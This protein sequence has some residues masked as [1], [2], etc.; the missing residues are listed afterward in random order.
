MIRVLAIGHLSYD[1]TFPLDDFPEENTKIQIPEIYESAGGPAA[2]AAALLAC[3]KIPT[4]FAGLVGADSYGLRAVMDLKTHGVDTRLV[5]NRENYSTPLSF[6]LVNKMNGSR[7]IVNRKGEGA[8]HP[9]D[10]RKFFAPF[11]SNPPELLLFDGHE[12]EVSLAAI[13]C[14][15]EAVTVLD[16][17]SRRTGTELLAMRVDYCIASERFAR[18][19]IPGKSIEHTFSYRELLEALLTLGVR[20]P[21]VTL[22]E[23]GCCFLETQEKAEAFLLPAYPARAVDTTGAGDIFHGA[24]AAALLQGKSFREALRVATAASAL[25]VERYGGMTSI[26]T[27]EEV[28]QKI[29]GDNVWRSL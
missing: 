16:A 15:P 8:L 12:P 9:E 11:L 21:A 7:T 17:G 3:W 19:F 1:I 14:F 28:E 24:F 2:N 18:E 25:S 22:G 26:P 6:I 20:C 29:I 10:P 27:L 5:E 13:E 4:A 23:R